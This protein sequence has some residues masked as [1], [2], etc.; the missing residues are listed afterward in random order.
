M[1]GGQRPAQRAAPRGRPQWVK[2]PL[3]K[4][5]PDFPNRMTPKRGKGTSDIS[6]LSNAA[7]N[8]GGG[9]VTPLPLP[10]G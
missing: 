2:L 4:G 8:R 3:L 7:S 6:T 1:I 10:R 5:S 9:G